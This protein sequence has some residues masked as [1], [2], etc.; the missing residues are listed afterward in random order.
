MMWDMQSDPQLPGS[1]GRAFT[2][3]NAREA[4]VSE[5]RLLRKDLRRPFHGVRARDPA[6]DADHVRTRCLEYAPR[7]KDWQFFS[8]ETALALLGAPLPEWPHRVALH[9]SAHR[10]RREPRVD[11]VIGHRLQLRDPASTITDDGLTIEH[12]VR[13]WR[14]SA[15][16]W[17]LDELI[18]TADW[19]LSDAGAARSV[20]ALRAELESMGDARGTLHR[21]LAQARS[22]VRSPQETRLRLAIVRA[23]LP[24]PRAGYVLLTASNA[25]VAELDLAYPRWKVAVEYDGRIH[26][27]SSR[28]FERDADRWE[29]I[30]REGWRLVRIL[31]HHVRS[32]SAPGMVAEALLEAGWHPGATSEHRPDGS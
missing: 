15:G 12:P 28:Q 16:L 14:Q 26:A 3:R 8:H 6:T 9:V 4:G 5:S 24:E 27:E 29:I 31:R 10:P 23:G 18:A 19:L 11:G 7:L 25:F 30:R 22:G 20:A 1:L 2:V 21:A 32:G 17:S 13:A